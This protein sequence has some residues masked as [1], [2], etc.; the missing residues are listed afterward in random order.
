MLIGISLKNQG[1]KISLNKN[2]KKELT[3]NEY[4]SGGYSTNKGGYKHK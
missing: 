2:Y 1:E 4:C 3:C